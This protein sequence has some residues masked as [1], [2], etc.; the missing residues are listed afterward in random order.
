MMRIWCSNKSHTKLIFNCLLHMLEWYEE[1]WMRI[2]TLK[3]KAF[4]WENVMYGDFYT[5]FHRYDISFQIHPL[6]YIRPY[7]WL[8]VYHW[9]I[10]ILHQA[11]WSQCLVIWFVQIL[12][13]LT[14]VCASK[15][16]RP[17]MKKNECHRT[18][19]NHFSFSKQ[20]PSLGLYHE[21]ISWKIQKNV[22]DCVQIMK[23]K[24]FG[25]QR[26]AL[27]CLKN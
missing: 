5:L 2:V 11:S 4:L 9:V 1:V 21:F 19:V 8:C 17:I 10:L 13:E 24:N 23:I 7:K 22:I 12:K 18:E 20:C 14:K 3:K 25:S 15:K 16:C 6:F 26:L 27:P